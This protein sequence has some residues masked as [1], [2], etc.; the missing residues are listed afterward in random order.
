MEPSTLILRF[1]GVAQL[2][3]IFGLAVRDLRFSFVEYLVA[4]LCF[5]VASRLIWPV[6]GVQVDRIP[7]A[8]I[9]WAFR[10]A[11][12]RHGYVAIIAAGMV[13]PT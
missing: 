10:R 3:I 11:Q 9:D 1:I 2:A 12:R 4:L 8:D 5:G 7:L 13:G 6:I